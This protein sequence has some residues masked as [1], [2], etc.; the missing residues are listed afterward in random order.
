[1]IEISNS[2]DFF[3]Y[4]KQLKVIPF[5]QSEAWYAM[6]VAKGATARF[7]VDAKTNTSIAIWGVESK[8]PL[9]NSIIFR[10]SGEARTAELDEKTVQAFYNTLASLFKAIEIDSN[11][12]YNVE[13][14]V[15]LRRAGYKRPI[16][17]FSCPLTLVND[18]VKE[19]QIRSRSW[20]RNVKIAEKANLVVKEVG[21]PDNTH[22]NDFVALFQEMSK[23]KEM[24]HVVSFEEISSLL[25]HNSIKLYAIATPKNEVLAYRIVQVHN[26]YA[27]DIFAAN[28]NK[29]RNY[30]GAT[31]LLVEQLFK[32]LKEEGVRYFDFGRIP[33]SNHSTDKIYEFKIGARG[34]KVQ[35]NGEWANYKS[36]TIEILVFFYK[37]FKLKKQR[38]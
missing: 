7:F 35:Y 17:V 30:R 11:T 19:Q 38:Y 37:Y 29:S 13:M 14:E 3:R 24:T 26:D 22:I 23:T 5:T 20:K 27:Y 21:N 28:S 25:A 31:Y 12:K 15:G 6:A 2:E 4:Q 10:V 8:V 34:E 16:G 36:L 18:L 9:F 1:M 33:P 32:S